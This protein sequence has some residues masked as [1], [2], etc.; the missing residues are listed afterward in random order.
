M[1][2]AAY[3]ATAQHAVRQGKALADNLARVFSGLRPH[4]CNINIRSP[5]SL[6][7]LGCRTGVAKVFGIRLS[8]FPA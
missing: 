5:G 6:A 3:P 8:G 1:N 2:G 7:A 4:P